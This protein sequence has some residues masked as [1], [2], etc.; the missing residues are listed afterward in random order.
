ML[1]AF[2]KR[3]EVGKER[4]EWNIASN[5]FFTLNRRHWTG[6]DKFRFRGCLNNRVL[7]KYKTRSA[8]FYYFCL[9]KAS[10][11]APL[12]N[13]NLVSICFFRLK[14]VIEAEAIYLALRTVWESSPWDV[15]EFAA[16]E[17]P[18]VASSIWGSTVSKDVAISSWSGELKPT[19][20]FPIGKQDSEWRP[21]LSKAYCGSY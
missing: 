16:P 6:C 14:S 5:W 13:S 1:K 10:K 17:K 4:T 18:C 9:A 3:S 11:E 7:I 20:L 8:A 19:L 15:E 2:S 21:D 12:K